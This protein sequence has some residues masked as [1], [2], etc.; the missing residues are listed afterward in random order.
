VSD[1]DF[2]EIEREREE[3]LAEEAGERLGGSEEDEE[4]LDEAAWRKAS[5]PFPSTPLEHALAPEFQAWLVG[6]VVVSA[7]VLV[8]ALAVL[9]LML[10]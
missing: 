4:E 7:A 8:A 9:Q 5:L 3:R 2:R 6:A 10:P 1:P